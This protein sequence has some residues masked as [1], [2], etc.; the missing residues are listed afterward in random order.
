MGVPARGA[1]LPVASDGASASWHALSLLPCGVHMLRA[2][3]D[4]VLHGICRSADWSCAAYM[5]RR[6]C[7]RQ[8]RPPLGAPACA[9]QQGSRKP[10]WPLACCCTCCVLV[11]LGAGLHGSSSSADRAPC[12]MVIAEMCAA[13]VLQATWSFW[14]ASMPP[15]PRLPLWSRTRQTMTSISS[16]PCSSRHSPS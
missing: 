13:S 3:F 1:C 9:V 8:P 16:D 14:R 12:C 5:F 10:A 4:C 11:D 6:S 7:L 2:G 15:S